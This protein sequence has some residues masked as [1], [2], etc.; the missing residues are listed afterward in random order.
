MPRGTH[1]SSRACIWFMVRGFRCRVFETWKHFRRFLVWGLWIGV[2]DLEFQVKERCRVYNVWCMVYGFMGS[3]VSMIHPAPRGMCTSDTC[4]FDGVRQVMRNQ[5]SR[6]N[7][8]DWV[9]WIGVG[10]RA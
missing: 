6:S 9:Q 4:G 3:G 10:L 7:L 5:V 8:R 2:P 1:A